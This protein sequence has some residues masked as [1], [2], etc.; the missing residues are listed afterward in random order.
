[1]NEGFRDGGE[2]LFRFQHM[3]GRELRSSHAQP[4]GDEG[5]KLT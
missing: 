3:L 1:L 4:A 2:D 5:V